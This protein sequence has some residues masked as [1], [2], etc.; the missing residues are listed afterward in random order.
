[1]DRE[2]KEALTPQADG[3]A[4]FEELGLCLPLDDI[5]QCSENDSELDMLRRLWRGLGQLP[6]VLNVIDQYFEVAARELLPLDSLPRHDSQ[7]ESP[8]GDWLESCHR[9]LREVSGAALGKSIKSLQQVVDGTKGYLNGNLKVRLG[10]RLARHL[11][12]AQEIERLLNESLAVPPELNRPYQIRQALVGQLF[13]DLNQGIAIVNAL[14]RTFPTRVLEDGV[15]ARL[16][17]FEG[18]LYRIRATLKRWRDNPSQKL[19]RKMM[20]LS[21]RF[22]AVRHGLVDLRSDTKHQCEDLGVVFWNRHG[23]V[24]KGLHYDKSNS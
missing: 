3:K 4:L 9:A 11:E 20:E 18:E 13:I 16:Y 24:Q 21:A 1:M 5:L 22:T 23:P 15:F 14:R 19:G 12:E 8:S 2:L 10:D 7:V 6:L 17:S